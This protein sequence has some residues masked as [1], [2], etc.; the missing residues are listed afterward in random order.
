VVTL[1][2]WSLP[3]RINGDWKEFH[4]V[5]KP[6]VREIADGMKANLWACSMCVVLRITHRPRGKIEHYNHVRYQRK[7]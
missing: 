6:A 1:K 4:L 2:G 5:A 7:H 3:W